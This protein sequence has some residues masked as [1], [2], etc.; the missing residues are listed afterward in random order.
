MHTIDLHVHSNFSD[1]TCSPEDLIELAYK[2]NLSA[3]ALTDHDCVEGLE[4]AFA[5]LK[6]MGYPLELIPGTEL[7]VDYNH[8]EIHLVGLFIDIHNQKLIKQTTDFVNKRKQRNLDM[9]KNFQ[10][11]GIPM[12]AEELSGGN[13]NAVITR[14]H[15]ARY[16]IEHGVAKD[17]KEAFSKYL[18]EDSPFYVKRTRTAAI[19]GIHLICEAGGVPILAH[20]LHYKLPEPTLRAMIQEFKEHGLRGIEVMYSNHFAADEVFVKRLAKEYDL[21]PSGGSDFH[22]KN[23]PSID[24]GSGRGNLTI[25]Y[26][27]LVDLAACVDYP[28]HQKA[29]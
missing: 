26:Q 5:Y 1:G 18:G 15:F 11:A 12:T 8:H 17:S 7:S 13:P 20:P 22:G 29:D 2:K 23:K 6:K 9:I 24:L 25:P 4:P 10:K 3:F 27:Y 14:A 21:L 16:L 28:L 19:D